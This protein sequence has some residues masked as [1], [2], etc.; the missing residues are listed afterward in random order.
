MGL[1][2]LETNFADINITFFTEGL[3]FLS[4]YNCLH[5]SF[6]KHMQHNFYEL[7]NYSVQ[8]VFQTVWQMVSSEDDP[9]W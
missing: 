5:Y 4:F 8:N 6:H 2:S 7:G 1:I 3:M 9:L